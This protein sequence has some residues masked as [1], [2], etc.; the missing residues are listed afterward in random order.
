MKGKSDSPP[1]GALFLAHILA[2]LLLIENQD[3]K[4]IQLK[5]S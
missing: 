2:S 5:I 4:L 1:P 3:E